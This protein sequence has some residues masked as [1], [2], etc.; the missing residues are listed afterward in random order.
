MLLQIIPMDNYKNI[1]I[2]NNFNLIENYKVKGIV[3]KYDIDLYGHTFEDFEWIQTKFYY[4]NFYT[5]SIF[6]FKDYWS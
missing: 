2:K 6:Y 5:Y 3:E 4:C 1:E